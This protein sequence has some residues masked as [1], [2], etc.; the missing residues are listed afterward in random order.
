MSF[1]VDTGSVYGAIVE[2]LACIKLCRYSRAKIAVAES[3]PRAD[4]RSVG[5]IDKISSVTERRA[6]MS[7]I[8]HERCYT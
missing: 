2:R 1:V 7:A 6:G 3:V 4:T 5:V 8:A